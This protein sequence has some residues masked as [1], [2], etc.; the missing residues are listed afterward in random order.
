MVAP[1]Q[2]AAAVRVHDMPSAAPAAPTASVPPDLR[3][4]AL[5]PIIDSMRKMSFSSRDTARAADIFDMA[6]R[7]KGFGYVYR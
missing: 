6:L 5:R 7:E 1:A 3:R 2:S 4:N